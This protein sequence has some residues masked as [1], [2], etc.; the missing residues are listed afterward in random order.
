MFLVT[1]GSRT[2]HR[3]R[4]H[5]NVTTISD[6]LAGLIMSQGRRHAWVYPAV[7]ARNGKAG[8]VRLGMRGH[9]VETPGG[10]GSANH[11][12]ARGSL[13]LVAAG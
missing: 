12:G 7:R 8:E 9:D 11:L 5:V 4:A 10:L 6:A 2:L 3:S 1:L 13:S